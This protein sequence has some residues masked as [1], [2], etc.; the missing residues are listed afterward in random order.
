HSCL[1]IELAHGCRQRF[2]AL[3]DAALRHLPQPVGSG[4]L[5]VGERD[6]AA[7]P[8][9]S[10]AVQR[11]DADAGPVGQALGINRLVP[12]H[13]NQPFSGSSAIAET[14][15]IS[16]PRRFAS[17]AQVATASTVTAK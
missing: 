12:C 11:H 13:G 8:D 10:L 3:V 14:G 16:M 2:L 6:A 17:S 1:F 7:C 15:T 9:Q 4:H 5:A